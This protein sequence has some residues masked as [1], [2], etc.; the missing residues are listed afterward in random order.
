MRGVEVKGLEAGSPRLRREHRK[1][2]DRTDGDWDQLV[3]IVKG[4][5][6]FFLEDA[7]D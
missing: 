6:R 4:Y 5:I 3:G 7:A 2:C 1:G